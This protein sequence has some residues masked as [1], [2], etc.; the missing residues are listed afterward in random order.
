MGLQVLP[1]ELDGRFERTLFSSFHLGFG[2]VPADSEAMRATC[3]VLPLVQFRDLFASAEDG[4]RLSRGLR[5]EHLVRLARVDQEGNAR[6][7]DF[8]SR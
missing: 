2:Q 6:S 3:K 7:F 1:E 4:I 8:L 5:R